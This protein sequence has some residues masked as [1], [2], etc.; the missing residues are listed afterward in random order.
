MRLVRAEISD[1]GRRVRFEAFDASAAAARI[2]D[3]RGDCFA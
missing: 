3:E 1:K 2:F